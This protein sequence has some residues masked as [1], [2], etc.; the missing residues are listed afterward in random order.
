MGVRTPVVIVTHEP[1]M[2][3]G[4]LETLAML[5]GRGTVH[6]VDDSGDAAW[7]TELATMVDEVVPVATDPHQGYAAAMRTTGNPHRRR[8]RPDKAAH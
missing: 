8:R 3:R 1:H 2:A 7:R 4:A 6:A 5:D